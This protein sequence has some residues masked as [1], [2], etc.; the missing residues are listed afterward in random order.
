MIE[1]SR[2]KIGIEMGFLSKTVD[3]FDWML[4]SCLPKERNTQPRA[5]NSIPGRIYH[6]VLTLSI[7]QY[8]KKK[9]KKKKNRFFQKFD[10]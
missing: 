8:R 1:L 9:K 7:N 5:Y 2:G 6:P 10:H 4:C 3:L